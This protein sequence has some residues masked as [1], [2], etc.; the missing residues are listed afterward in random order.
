[1]DINISKL[2]ETIVTRNTTMEALAYDMGMARSTL[3][4]KLKRGSS[5]LTLKDVSDISKSLSL[6]QAETFS[7]FGGYNVTRM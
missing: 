4:R 6:S 7:I 1:M 5:A 2:K 3:Y